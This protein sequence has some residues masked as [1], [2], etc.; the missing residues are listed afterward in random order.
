MPSWLTF[1]LTRDRHYGDGRLGDRANSSSSTPAASSL[2]RP[3][4]S[5]KRWP[6]R[7]ARPWPEAD[8]VV[9]VVDVRLG[10]SAQDQDIARFW[11]QGQQARASGREQ[12]RGHGESPLLAE[13]HELG[14]GE[15]HPI[16]AAHGQGIRSLLDAVLEPLTPTGATK[17][18]PRTA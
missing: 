14:M 1:G 13:F 9:F 5:L 18:A 11:R 7:P 8:A 16:S 10:L 12:G 6:S 2:T 4:A 15:P 3:P 17:T